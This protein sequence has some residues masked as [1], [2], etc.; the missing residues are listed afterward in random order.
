LIKLLVEL[1]NGADNTFLSMPRE[2]NLFFSASKLTS[3]ELVIFG[4]FTI[5]ECVGSL[6]LE[7]DG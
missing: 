2:L 1:L 6:H 7:V 3:L 4:K 5:L